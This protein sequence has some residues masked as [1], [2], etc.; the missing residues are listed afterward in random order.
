[1]F[2]SLSAL[3]WVPMSDL[4]SVRDVVG[5]VVLAGAAIG[6]SQA[7]LLS[8]RDLLREGEAGTS[9]RITLDRNEISW[10][11]S[12]AGTLP[13][14]RVRH[15]VVTAR[16]MGRR[17]LRIATAGPLPVS[18]VTAPGPVQYVRR[19]LSPSRF[20]L[21]VCVDRLDLPPSTVVGA[22]RQASAGR[23]PDAYSSEQFPPDQEDV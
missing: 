11:G 15:V 21:D 18:A 5:W 4:G 20:A 23:F 3:V 9:L 16:P 17:R 19:L 10:S 7:L 8:G 6:F 13:W 2:V 14:E 22:I 1:M 12:R